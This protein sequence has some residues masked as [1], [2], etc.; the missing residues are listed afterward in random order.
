VIL[1]EKAIGFVEFQTVSAGIMA[2]DAM[3][4]AADIELLEAQTVCPGKYIVLF[5][6]SLSSVNAA[7]ETSRKSYG[8]MLIDDFVLGNPDEG[9]FK[10]MNGTTEITGLE[11]LGVIETFSAAA[12]IT[13]ADTAAKTARVTLMEI[14]LARG[15]CGKSF[16]LLTGELAAVEASV[17]AACKGASEKG[18]LLAKAV[19]PNPDKKLWEK[20][21]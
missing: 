12:A 5:C 3:I 11:A 19:I 13:A 15:M 16:V 18:M 2:A 21:L 14:R 9:I 1:L 20:L 6:G 7:M 8:S 17:E 4:K 10:A